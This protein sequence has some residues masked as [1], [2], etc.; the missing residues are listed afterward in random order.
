M[1]D[2]SRMDLDVPTVCGPYSTCELAG[3][4]VVQVMVA[5]ERVT[6]LESI[7]VKSGGAA[8]GVTVG[9]VLAVGFTVWVM[10]G[11]LVDVPVGI[12]VCVLARVGVRV[13]VGVPVGPP[14]VRVAVSVG[15]GVDE[16]PGI[17]MLVAEA[18]GVG[19]LVAEAVLVAAGVM[20]AVAVA[21]AVAVRV[22][23]P[24]CW[25]RL[26]CNGSVRALAT[27]SAISAHTRASRPITGAPECHH[28]A[29][30]V[31]SL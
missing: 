30:C 21:L 2:V 12:T 28:T 20:V 27:S 6:L 23:V 19:V 29:G 31:Q 9:V 14:G 8:V 10:V 26:T 15:D 17:G 3:S 4:F 1:S 16:A 25:A 13:T 7:A 24:A 18:P 11:T 5:L 22:G